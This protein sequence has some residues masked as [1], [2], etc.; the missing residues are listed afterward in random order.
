[1]PGSGASR[2]VVATTALRSGSNNHKTDKNNNDNNNND[3]NNNDDNN[4]NNNDNYNYNN[5]NSMLFV[6]KKMGCDILWLE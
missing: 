1:M 4:N 3:N 5:Y 6:C 2:K